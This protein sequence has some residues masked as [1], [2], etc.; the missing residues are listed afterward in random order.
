MY[1]VFDCQTSGGGS[2]NVMAA[3][4]KAKDDGV[5]LVSMSLAVGMPYLDG[6]GDPLAGVVKTLTDAG[7]GVVVANANDGVASS[8]ANELYTEE[9]PSTEPSAIGVGAVANSNFPITY[10]ATDSFGSQVRY[11]AVWPITNATLD[12]YLVDDGCSRDSWQDSMTAVNATGKMDTT[13]FAFAMTDDCRPVDT[14]VCC[15]NTVAPKYVMGLLANTSRIYNKEYNL[16]SQARLGTS[17]SI[18]LDIANAAQVTSN[19]NKAG[20]FGKYKVKFSSAAFSS[21]VQGTGGMVDYYSSFGPERLTYKLKPQLSAPGGN[22]LSTYPL[23]PL[24]GYGVLS[25]TSMA[26]PYIAG[27]YALVKSKFP[28]ATPEQI[29]DLLQTTSSPMK[30]IWDTSILSATPQQGAGLV[31]AFKAITSQ[32]QVSPGQLLISDVTKTIYGTSNITVTNKSPWPKAYTFSHQGAGYMDAILDYGQKNQIAKYGNASFSPASVW[33][34]PGKSAVINVT[35]TPPSDVTVTK[36]PVFGGFVKVHDMS[37]FED[38]SVPYVGPPFSLFNAPYIY[39]YHSDDVNLPEIWFKYPDGSDATVINLLEFN[40]TM[41]YGS[42]AS[43]SLWTSEYRVD[44]LPANTSFPS[45]SKG[46]DVKVPYTYHSSAIPP[47][48]SFL[49]FPSYGNLKDITRLSSPANN[50]SPFGGPGMTV[51]GD[52]GVTYTLAAGDYRWLVSVLRWGGD[53]SLVKD[54]DSWLGPVIRVVDGQATL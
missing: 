45:V 48:S 19:Y 24:G 50:Y 42:A 31:N 26:T 36:M 11:A 18:S 38:F 47:K 40:N 32:S 28:K 22:I 49:G 27:C 46:Y 34:A 8:I 33:L 51:K 20:G 10:G 16:P 43:Y 14:T 1:R 41:E 37:G 23:G 2:D 7:I 3:M 25:G 35:I 21:P 15:S 17:Q 44:V 6:Q 54:Y 29:R 5:D 53:P 4:L 52:D 13:I 30:W 9:W 12:V 39:Q